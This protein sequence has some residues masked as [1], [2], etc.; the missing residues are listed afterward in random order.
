MRP[1]TWSVPASEINKHIVL[2]R[3]A[4]GE[5]TIG[6]SERNACC[7]KGKRRMERSEGRG[8]LIQEKMKTE[9]NKDTVL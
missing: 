9:L 1:G 5:S 3:R 7:K 4:E 6:S 2:C 8:I